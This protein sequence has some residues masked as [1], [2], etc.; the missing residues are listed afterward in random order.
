MSAARRGVQRNTRHGH[1]HEEQVNTGKQSH[2]RN[3]VEQRLPVNMVTVLKT[4]ITMS[5]SFKFK[6]N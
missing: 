2:V 6:T 4:R 3:L 1:E 5:R